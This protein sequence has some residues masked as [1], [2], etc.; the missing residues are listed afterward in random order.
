MGKVVENRF[1]DKMGMENP[2]EMRLDLPG[3]EAA[4]GMGFLLVC[5]ETAKSALKLKGKSTDKK[6][7]SCNIGH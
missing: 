7:N 5:T 4:E 6:K 2:F 1:E 3:K